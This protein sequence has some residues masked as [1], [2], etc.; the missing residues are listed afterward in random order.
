MT[1][2]TAALL[3]GVIFIAVGLLGYINNPIIG[4]S[5]DAI[6]HADSTHNM[7]HIVSGALFVLVALA[8]PA[9]A[10]GFMILF[11]IVYLLI[12]IVGLSAIGSDGMAKILGFLHVN[13]NDNYLHIGLGVV[14]VL[15]GLTTRRIGVR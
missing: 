3:I 13:G 2:K 7:V 11:G 15:L 1:S 6:F 10:K 14:I 9:A 12:G 8:A 4:D 5:P